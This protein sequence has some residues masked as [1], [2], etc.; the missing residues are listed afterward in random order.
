[1]IQHKR[2][3]FAHSLYICV[4]GTISPP[5]NVVFAIIYVNILRVC[6]SVYM[7][8]GRVVCAGRENK[9]TTL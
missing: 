1:M 2:Q 8:C 3:T 7:N 5:F 6:V 9:S 4:C